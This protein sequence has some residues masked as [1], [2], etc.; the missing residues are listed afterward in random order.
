MCLRFSPTGLHDIEKELDLFSFTT[1]SI[2][3]LLLHVHH[4]LILCLLASFVLQYLLLSCISPSFT[5]L[6]LTFLLLPSPLM[7]VLS[8]L[9]F[10][11]CSL[12]PIYLL[13]FITPS[14]SQFPSQSLTFLLLP[15][16]LPSLSHL[17]ITSSFL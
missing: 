12:F 10:F 3:S 2:P 4:Y 7:I 8:S 5:P 13:S 1:S 14:V 9:P 15:P 16:V 6:P 17:F 11:P